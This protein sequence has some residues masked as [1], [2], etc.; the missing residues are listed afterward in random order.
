[1][2]VYILSYLIKLITFYIIVKSKIDKFQ[3]TV[4]F[5]YNN[6]EE[7]R[8]QNYLF[9]KI[10]IGNLDKDKIKE[11]VYVEHNEGM[12]GASYLHIIKLRE[13]LKDYKYPLNQVYDIEIKKFKEYPYPVIIAQDDSFKRFFSFDI[14]HNSIAPKVIASFKNG[15]LKVIPKLMKKYAKV[16]YK[17]KK[18]NYPIES[19]LKEREFGNILNKMAFYYYIKDKKSF[20]NL[21]HK[22]IH[23]KNK[24]FK[25]EFLNRFK[26]IVKKSVFLQNAFY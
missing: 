12:H 16:S 15:K 26:K 5:L 4:Y 21:I 25:K 7:K 22:Y 23:F 20:F 9:S 17:L 2:G 14:N 3:E 11:L 10:F 19:E 13:G 24:K 8:I 6:K 1:M 18:V